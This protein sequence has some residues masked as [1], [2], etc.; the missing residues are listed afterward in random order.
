M[1][2]VPTS[3]SR[4]SLLAGGAVDIAQFL[5]PREYES[6]KNNPNATYDA[7]RASYM[8]WLELNTKIKPFDDVKVRQAMNLAIPRDEIIRTIYYGLADPL[9]APMPYIYP[10]A[11]Q[12]FFR[13]GY[14]L[15]EAKRLLAEAGL[16][17]GFKTTLSYNAGDPTQEPIA[18]LYQTSLRQVG[19]DVTLEKLPAGV[20]YENVTKRLKPMTCDGKTVHVVGIP[21]HWGFTGA[22]RKGFGPNSLTPFVGDAN[23]ETPEFK[24]FLVNI[25]KSTGPGGPVA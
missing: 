20:F 6:L 2:E 8:I 7:V 12:S 22:A 25:E 1:R 16:A 18:L 3:A 17:G 10:M 11:D 5:Q 24:A 13:Y 21:L 15:E 14:N 23:V 9:T 19:I 4:L